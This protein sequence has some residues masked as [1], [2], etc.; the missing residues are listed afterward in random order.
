MGEAF[1]EAAGLPG[2]D[3]PAGPESPNDY[4]K[5][6]VMNKKLLI[7]GAGGHGKVVADIACDMKVWDEVCFV[8]DQYPEMNRLGLW[9]VIGRL[10]DVC[11]LR[12][13]FSDV[14][15]ALGENRL[16]VKWLKECLDLGFEAPVIRHPSVAV[17][18]MAKI[19]LGSVLVAK[20]AVNADA[21]IG[22]GG[23]V[24]TG[25]T[26]GHDCKLAEGVHVAPGVNLAGAS[27]VGAYS[28][29]GIGS[30]VLQKVRIGKD[31]MVGA[32]AVVIRDVPDG[33]TVVG[34]PG[35]VIR[36]ANEP[37]I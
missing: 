8:D 25:A 19:G 31:V 2:G 10:E 16:R 5:D 24:N 1:A 35:R 7:I 14:V 26:I 9:E 28:W 12:N 37:D 32:G 17:S 30:R 34:V 36:T 4:A 18:I 33:S 11:S 29:I 3:E 15:V 27:E 6:E 20:S 22:L 21:V 23:I 13:R